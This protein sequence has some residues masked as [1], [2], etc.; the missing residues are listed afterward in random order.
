MA[1]RYPLT[2]EEIALFK[3][4]VWFT[5]E[6]GQLQFNTSEETITYEGQEAVQVLQRFEWWRK[7]KRWM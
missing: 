6:D 1:E 4:V 7:N 5:C 2:L 3:C